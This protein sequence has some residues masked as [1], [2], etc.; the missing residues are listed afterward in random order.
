MTFLNNVVD[1]FSEGQDYPRDFCK[2]DVCKG[3]CVPESLVFSRVA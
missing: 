3:N 2:V 1:T